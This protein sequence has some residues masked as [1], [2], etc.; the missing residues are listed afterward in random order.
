A[1]LEGEG[2]AIEG[3]QIV[4]CASLKRRAEVGGGRELALGQ[5]INTIIFN[6][7]DHREV[8]PNQ[9]HELSDADGGGVAIAGHADA[10]HSVVG[11]ER[12]GRDGGH[13][14][15]DAVEAVREAEEV[16]RRLRR[17]ADAG[18]LRDVKR[19]DAHIVEALYDALGDGVVSASGAESGLAAF[20][21]D[22]LEA[23]TIG[24]LGG[25]GG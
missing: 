4:G 25:Y 18:E 14:S 19:A 23:E 1:P 6:D 16:G 21:V 13:A 8:A 7:V 22:D 24:L 15:V 11:E 12:A 9:V 20:I 3:R 5:A 2:A 10:E 17:A